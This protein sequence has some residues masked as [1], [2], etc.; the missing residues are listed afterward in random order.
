MNL[1][2]VLSMLAQAETAE[3]LKAVAPAARRL[4]ETDRETARWAYAYAA[5][6]L[7]EREVHSDP[8]PR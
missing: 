1:E 2:F 8:P 5:T 4:S 7:R 3:E 6:Q